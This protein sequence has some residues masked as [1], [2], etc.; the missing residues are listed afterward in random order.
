RGGSAERSP[1]PSTSFSPQRSPSWG[2]P[3]PA[4]VQAGQVVAQLSMPY[5][6]PPNQVLRFVGG[7]PEFGSWDPAA[8]PPF[9]CDG[10]DMWQSSVALWPGYYQFKAVLLDT[11]SGEA[12]WEPGPMRALTVPE[13]PGGGLLILNCTWC[14]FEMEALFLWDPVTSGDALEGGNVDGMRPQTRRRTAAGAGALALRVIR[15]RGCTVSASAVRGNLEMFVCGGRMKAYTAPEREVMSIQFHC[16]VI[17]AQQFD[18]RF[19]GRR[20][21]LNS[22]RVNGVAHSRVCQ[23]GLGRPDG[24]HM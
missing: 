3:S 24:L 18:C 12:V 6:L 4:D 7:R 22:V 21:E 1:S 20:G 11:D 23:V 14:D 15:V 13:E 5:S 2:S 8:A 16:R 9:T 10:Q 19:H 17:K